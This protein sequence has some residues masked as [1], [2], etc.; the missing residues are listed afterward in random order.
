MEKKYRYIPAIVAL[1]AALAVSVIA[2]LR[3]C[4]TTTALLLIFISTISFY[5]F[6]LLTRFLLIKTETKKENKPDKETEDEQ[7][8]DD[9]ES[10]NETDNEDK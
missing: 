7:N 5:I 4:S 3:D 10:E 2:F 8:T 1:L 9:D 6:G